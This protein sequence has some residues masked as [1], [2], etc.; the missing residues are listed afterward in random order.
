[1]SGLPRAPSVTAWSRGVGGAELTRRS[2]R[3]RA[4]VRRVT[5][6]GPRLWRTSRADVGRGGH[7]GPTVG[8]DLVDHRRLGD[9]RDEPH[10]PVT[11]RT[12]EPVDLE[13][14]PEEGCRMAFARIPRGRL[15][16]QP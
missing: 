8:E 9:E 2:G 12:R 3:W 1:M 4:G 6:R 11:R 7:A 16:Y 14:L 15:A 10:G 13:E 5:C